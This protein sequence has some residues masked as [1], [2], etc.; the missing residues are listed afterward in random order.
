MMKTTKILLCITLMSTVASAGDWTHWRG[1][2]WNGTSSERGLVDT[3]SRDGENLRFRIDFTG[4]STPVIVDGR[5]CATGRVGEGIHRQE[6]AAC[7]D[8]DSGAPIWETRFNVYQTTVP[9]QRVGWANPAAD[10][11]TGYLYVQGVGGLF[12]CFDSRDGRLVWSR[13]LIE[14]FGFMEG[15]GG[16]TQTP[17]IDE[18]RVIVT[19]S[20]AGW[21]D[22]ASPRHRM[23]AF[24]KETGVLRWVST[25]GRALEDKNTQSTPAVAVVNGERILIHGNGDGWIY[26]VQ[27]RTGEKVWEFNLSQRGIN[28]SPVVSGATVYVA[29][30][31]ENVDEG[32]MGRVVAIDATGTGDVTASHEIWR[33]PLGVGFSSPALHEG[34]LYVIDNSANLHALDAATGAHKWDFNLGRVGKGSPVWADGKIYATEVNGRFLILEETADGATLLDMEEIPF[35]DRRLAEVYSSPAVAN[36]RV[37]FATEEGIYCL[38]GE[39]GATETATENAPKLGEEAPAGTEVAIL[40]VVP[41]DLAI[42]P[43]DTVEFEAWGFDAGGRLIGKQQ[44]TWT[45]QGLAG[46]V[47]ANGRF[48][49]P[50]DAPSAG[51]Y[52]VAAAGGLEASGRVRVLQELPYE[53]GFETTEVDSRPSYQIAYVPAFKVAEHDGGK[54]LFKGPSPAKIHRHITFLGKADEANYTLEADVFASREGRQVADVGVINS[55]YTLELMGAHQELEIRSWPSA[56]RMYQAQ[57][58]PWE[59]DTWYRMKLRVSMEGDAAIIE[60]KVWPRG[61]AEPE[62]WTMTVRDPHG[63]PAGSP[64]L[65]AYSP[66]PVMFDN[67]VATRNP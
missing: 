27:A 24:D 5:L 31:E 44:A 14:E 3:W 9:W 39:G 51:G 49:S 22:Q 10:P 4:R 2:A 64:G 55:G 43:G 46:E 45:L 41:A 15:Y 38:E 56:R 17:L 21:G 18:D 26:A 35:D 1:P 37:Y 13:N 6:V 61:E 33:A 29:H 47:D 32:T 58:F 19:F 36:G 54:V 48:A 59:P 60:G 30:S 40:R 23:F 53:E 42:R 25:P 8:A 63:I 62:G 16:R 28:T 20:N 50:A 66:V 57:P 34:V 67:I 65:S 12:F 7:Y 11:E 52:V